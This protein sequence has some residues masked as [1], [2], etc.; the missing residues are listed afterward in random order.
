[1]T[2]TMK[3][4]SAD[5]LNNE[6]ESREKSIID[7]SERMEALERSVGELTKILSL[8]SMDLR[9]LKTKSDLKSQPK[10]ICSNV[11]TKY[12]ITADPTEKNLI[13]AQDIKVDDPML[14]DRKVNLIDQVKLHA[15]FN[16]IF[17][18]STQSM[19]FRDHKVLLSFIDS[20]QQRFAFHSVPENLKVQLFL[21][22][23]DGTENLIFFF[24]FHML[25]REITDDDS[26]MSPGDLQKWKWS[27]FKKEF[28]RL[29]LPKGTQRDIIEELARWD[30]NTF[31]NSKLNVISQFEMNVRYLSEVNKVTG[32][33]T[34]VN[35]LK[36]DHK[37][38]L[39]KTFQKETYKEIIQL[40]EVS[41]S[42]I[43]PN[44]PDVNDLKYDDLINILMTIKS[45]RE[46]EQSMFKNIKAPI[47]STSK[48]ENF[49]SPNVYDKNDESNKYV[50]YEFKSTGK[51]RF[52][53]RC[54]YLHDGNGKK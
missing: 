23:I 32:G 36:Q 19:D 5:T 49:V 51:C 44:Y 54:H 52:G 20:M 21:R 10:D 27:E 11:S 14:T 40:M 16:D 9:E 33:E 34:D 17:K 1:M 7:S 30:T 38:S 22:M 15:F 39:I 26:M 45:K 12:D 18:P 25:E 48:K 8:I 46:I 41:K 2:P 3:L 53:E 42:V 24:R 6:E 28:M 31:S 43:Y 29:F 35:R 47:A 50:C 4:R 13:V 37:V